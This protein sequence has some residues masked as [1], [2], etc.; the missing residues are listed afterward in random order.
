MLFRS[1]HA[2]LD[3]FQ[4]EPLPEGH[5]IWSHP[6]IRVTGHTSHSGNGTL[7]RG[8]DLFVANLELFLAGKPLINEAQPWEVGL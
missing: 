5:W 3:V 4:T 2:V 7:G 6:K 8:D 1:A